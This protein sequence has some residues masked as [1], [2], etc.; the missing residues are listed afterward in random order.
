MSTASQITSNV[1]LEDFH[2]PAEAAALG[3]TPAQGQEDL[4]PADQLP[5]AAN[6]LAE[7][8]PPEEYTAPELRKQ[9]ALES[10]TVPNRDFSWHLCGSGRRGRISGRRRLRCRGSR[11]HCSR[12]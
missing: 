3:V 11:F 12:R 6:A 2:S 8:F 7:L 10:S 4:V 1:E 5:S 9:E